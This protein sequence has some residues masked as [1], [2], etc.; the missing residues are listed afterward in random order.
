MSLAI[1]ILASGSGTNFDSIAASV[2]AGRIDARKK[3]ANPE[4]IE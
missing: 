1:G 2:A 3:D 4:N